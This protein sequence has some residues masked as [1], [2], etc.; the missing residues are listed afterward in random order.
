M[1]QDFYCN[2]AAM[3]VSGDGQV[4]TFGSGNGEDVGVV[5]EEDIGHAGLQQL[6][7]AGEVGF[8][9]SLVVD[10]GDVEAGVAKAEDAVSGTEEADAGAGS[11]RFGFGFAPGVDFVVAETAEKFSVDAEAAEEGDAVVEWVAA[12]GDKVAG[13]ETNVGAGFV[14]NGD[15]ALKVSGFEVGS[16]VDIGD[17]DK[18]ESVKIEWEV[19][20]GDFDFAELDVAP[21]GDDAVAERQRRGSNSEGL[22]GG[23][24]A[25]AAGMEA[26]FGFKPSPRGEEEGGDGGDN[27]PG[28]AGCLEPWPK[29]PV[30]QDG[31]GEEAGDNQASSQAGEDD[32]QRAGV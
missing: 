32:D 30:G 6:F 18:F 21:A 15:G 5:R 29:T 10:A 17:L 1:P 23:Q 9:L 24:Q 22:G 11:G 3:G 2:L 28:K 8:E 4:E 20:D 31:G 19:G 16:E 12:G 26:G 7:S 25:A 27:S 14:G 13:D